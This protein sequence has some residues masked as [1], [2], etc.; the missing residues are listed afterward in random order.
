MYR[1]S[2]IQYILLISVIYYILYIKY[3]R[4]NHEFIYTMTIPV[5]IFI[6]TYILLINL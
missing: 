5:Y 2:S 4:I 3:D 6:Y 1:L